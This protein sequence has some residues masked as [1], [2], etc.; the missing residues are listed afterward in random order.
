M[1]EVEVDGVD[2]LRNVAEVSV[3]MFRWGG[4]GGISQCKRDISAFIPSSQSI[5]RNTS[6][7]PKYNTKVYEKND[8]PKK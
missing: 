6:R 1:D 2:E 4:S 8:Q 3:L 7:S 5:C